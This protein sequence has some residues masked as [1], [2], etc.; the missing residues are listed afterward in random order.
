[1]VAHRLVKG[2]RRGRRKSWFSGRVSG[3]LE[4]KL[5]RWQEETRTWG[6]CAVGSGGHGLVSDCTARDWCGVAPGELRWAQPCVLKHPPPLPSMSPASCAAATLCP[7]CGT[8]RLWGPPRPV[9]IPAVW[10][11]RLQNSGN[12]RMGGREA[13][14]E[15]TGGT[16]WGQMQRLQVWTFLT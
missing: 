1:M 9:P 2:Q 7:R 3:T 16:G 15:C 10:A 12:G 11:T 14:G 5:N 6:S 13:G 4:V 8:Q